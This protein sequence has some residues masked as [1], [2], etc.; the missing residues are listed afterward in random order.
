MRPSTICLRQTSL[1]RKVNERGFTLIELMI[2]VGIIAILAAIALPSYQSYVLRSHRNAVKSQ[3]QEIA[4]RIATWRM[5][6]GSYAGL[7]DIT[8][9]ALYG[10][11]NF[12]MQGTARY[13]LNLTT[14]TNTDGLISGWQITATPTG[15][16][17]GD[18]IVC[19]NSAGQQFWQKAATAC[20]LSTTS[21][22]RD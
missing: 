10:S 14:T 20:A 16:Q 13:T 11:T 19:L 5:T 2:V 1:P 17:A 6:R 7:G 4:Q 22:W 9:T 3:M 18:G 12:P 8:N 21:S 15:P